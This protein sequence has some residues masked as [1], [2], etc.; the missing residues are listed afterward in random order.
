ML[1][2]NKGPTKQYFFSSL[3]TYHFT[4]YFKF[5]AAFYSILFLF[6]DILKFFITCI[7]FHK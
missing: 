7:D 6:L 5:S 1:V 2:C 4:L 3:V